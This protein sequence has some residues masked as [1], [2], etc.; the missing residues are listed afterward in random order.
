MFLQEINMLHE[1]G[2]N[3]NLVLSPLYFDNFRYT[4]HLVVVHLA[5]Y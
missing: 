1:F 4:L 3:Y 5:L 2:L